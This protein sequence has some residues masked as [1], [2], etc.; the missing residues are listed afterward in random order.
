MVEEWEVERKVDP[1]LIRRAEPAFVAGERETI[2]GWLEFHRLTLELKCEGLTDAQ[3]KA[4]PVATSAISLH[5]L[6]R[7]MAEVERSW[8]QDRLAEDHGIGYLWASD[9][10]PDADMVPLDDAVWED[11]LAT[12]QETCERS[13]EIAAVRGLDDVGSYPDG[14]PVSLR[15]IY[16]HM[17]EE[18]ARHNGHADLVR[19]LV[20][21][22]VGL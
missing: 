8:F 3:R 13:R 17:V 4:R 10:E 21:G 6:V 16:T 18:Y 7:H 9:E 22:A 1:A 14:T 2:E 20:D 11:D 19:E 15:W 12:F 5:G